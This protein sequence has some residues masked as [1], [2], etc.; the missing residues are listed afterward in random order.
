MKDEAASE[1]QGQSS[2]ELL[3]KQDPAGCAVIRIDGSGHRTID[4]VQSGFGAA[5]AGPHV[6]KELV[7][8]ADVT[9]VVEYLHYSPNLK[10]YSDDNNELGDRD[11]FDGVI[12]VGAESP[13]KSLETLLANTQSE[14]F[15]PELIKNLLAVRRGSQLISPKIAERICSGI[16]ATQDRNAYITSWK[17][18][19]YAPA[20]PAVESFAK[21]VLAEALGICRGEAIAY[22]YRCYPGMRSTLHADHDSDS[23]PYVLD[24]LARLRFPDEHAH[25]VKLWTRLLQLPAV[26]IE[27]AET[28]PFTLGCVLD[29]SEF[30]EISNNNGKLWQRVLAVYSRNQRPS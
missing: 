14:D 17:L 13:K 6:H 29:Q 2:G 12:P 11:W 9:C 3:L 28:V 30:K 8:E 20:L 15:L 7:P 22:L 1:R 24:A 4:A 5:L 27:L 18:L 10:V 26:P 23:D 21:A 25:S 16:S 19:E